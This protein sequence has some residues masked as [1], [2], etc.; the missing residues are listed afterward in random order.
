MK[1][2]PRHSTSIAPSVI[3]VFHWLIINISGE[4]HSFI[5]RLKK[6]GLKISGKAL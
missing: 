5:L 6:I 3:V 2:R 4:I 1:L